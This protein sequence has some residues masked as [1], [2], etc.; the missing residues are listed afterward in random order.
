MPYDPSRFMEKR[1]SNI[2]KRLGAS[3]QALVKIYKGKRLS[4]GRG[5]GGKGS[6][7]T[8]RIDT[9]QNFY[10]A[11]VR[12]N[13]ENSKEMSKATQAILKHY[14]GSLE[15]PQHEDCRE[16]ESCNRH[17]A[18]CQ[19]THEP[20]KNLLLQAVI[21]KIQP[22]FDKLGNKNF[23]AACEKCK[24]QNVNE[25][26]HNVFWMLARKSQYNSPY[27]TQFAVYLATILFNQ[28]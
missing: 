6:L 21:E 1:T 20:I 22:L 11:A 17:R 23:L 28:E 12:N 25:A 15:N 14:S 9:F 7:T 2:T 10:G 8:K 24:T 27:E 13:K 16:G 5:I 19:N 26:Y 3:L 4:D 18:T